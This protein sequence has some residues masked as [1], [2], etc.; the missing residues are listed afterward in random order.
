MPKIRFGWG[1]APDPAGGAQVHNSPRPPSWILG[2]LLIR[3]GKG[4]EDGL[5]MEGK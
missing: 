3:G 5:G 1:S 2:V 4:K